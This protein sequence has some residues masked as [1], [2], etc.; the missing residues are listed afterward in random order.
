MKNVLSLTL[1]LLISCSGSKKEKVAVQ[2]AHPWLSVKQP[3]SKRIDLLLKEMTLDEKMSQLRYDSPAIDRLNIKSY[4]WWNEALH[5][6]ARSARATVFPQTIGLAAT[7]DPDLV[8]RIG[9]AI[10]DEA[11]AIHNELTKAGKP[12]SQ[13]MGLTYWSPNVNMFRDP[14]WGRGQETYGEDPYL[15]SRMGVAFIRGMQ[16]EDPD[17]LKVATC[18]KHFAVHSGP[19]GERHG[20][21][22]L[23][24]P[25]EMAEYYFP[26]FKAS[27]EAGVEAIMCAYNRTN[28]EPCCGSPRLLQEVLRDQ[29]GFDGHVVSDC[30]AILDIQSG[31]QYTDS[32]VQAI[33]LAVESGVNL[34]CGQA[35]KQIDKAVNLGLVSEK[36]IDDL[37][38]PLLR[39]K[40]RLGF[41]DPEE[42]DPFRHLGAKDVNNEV[43]QQLA[44]EAAQ[45]SIVLLKNDNRTLPLKK[46]LDFV[47]MVGPLAGN[48]LSLLGNYNG[49]SQN[50]I[51][52]VEGVT[53]TVS[54]TTR[55]EYRPGVLLNAP[56]ANPIDWYSV[57]SRE[58]DATICV[59]GFSSLLE[60]EEG[61]AAASSTHGDN[62]TMQLP[63]SQLNLIRKLANDEKPVV[64]VVCAGSPVDLSEIE[65]LVDAIIYSWYPGEAG[66]QAVA[67]VIFGNSAPTGKLPITFPRDVSQLPEFNNY[68]LKGRTYRYM[69]KEPLYPFG[70]GLTYGQVELANLS[71][72]KKEDIL[73][74]QFEV[75]NKSDFQVNE[76]VQLYVKYDHPVVETPNYELVKFSRLSAEP[77]SKKTTSMDIEL[78]RFD[79]FNEKGEAIPFQGSADFFISTSSPGKAAQR[80]NQP[81]LMQR[82]TL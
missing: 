76:V 36:Q 51:T 54:T 45:K 30:G 7:F 52:I 80:L 68:E 61:E 8:N 42:S 77:T 46:E 20:F 39:T 47:Y 55:V 60:G 32:L 28:G 50:M 71:I 33:A 29:W 3:L 23:A 38:R 81:I 1:V 66:G 16:G 17:R 49:L 73:S 14:R 19:E 67:D 15:T 21:N 37:L 82:I 5:G 35:Y 56:N 43:H 22:A 57:Q 65:G 12:F 10:A 70:Y 64:L 62:P 78:E 63:A 13:Y 9:A 58:A 2:Y 48:M 11:R 69:E 44:L 24:S 41:F 72:E 4:N 6:V 40:F 75:E 59:V 25:K 74:I 26:A 53:K 79:I 18:A 34:N 31:H 27:V